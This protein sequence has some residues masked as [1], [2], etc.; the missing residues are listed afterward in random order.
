MTAA[1]ASGRAAAGSLPNKKMAPSVTKA[2]SNIHIQIM[3]VALRNRL[4]RGGNVWKA[5]HPLSKRKSERPSHSRA[6]AASN[7]GS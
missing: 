7:G 6:V 5:S 4:R 3:G 2:T 1:T